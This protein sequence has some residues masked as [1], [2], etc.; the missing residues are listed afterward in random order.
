MQKTLQK[1]PARDRAQVVKAV[2]SMVENPFAG[3]IV[4]L[5]GSI[6][7]R[8]RVGNYRLLFELDFDARI[9][10]VVDLKRRTSTTY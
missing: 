1:I 9:V 8:R 7:W 10:D 6:I 4:R 3:D 2:S 5:E